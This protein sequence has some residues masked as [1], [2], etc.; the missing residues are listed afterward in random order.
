MKKTP[1]L[2][3][4]IF[5]SIFLFTSSIE[6]PKAYSNGGYSTDPSNP[7][8]GSHDWIAQHAL[9]WLSA[10]E[11]QYI[12]DNLA[13]YLYGTELPDNGGAI[14]GIGDTT[15]HHIYFRANGSL[16]DGVAAHRA[17][18]EYQKALNFLIAKDYANAAKNAGIMS[19]YIAEVSVFAHVRGA[20]TDWG[21]ETGNIHSNYES[22][23]DTRTN[24]YFD[25]YSSYLLF[26]GN[27]QTI[28]AYDAARNL[29]FNTTFDNG[30][31]YTCVWMNNNYNT[32][33]PNSI[34]W[35][36]AG[37]SL[38]LAVNALTD[39]LHT[40]YASSNAQSTPTSS[41]TPTPTTT[42]TSTPSSTPTG[43]PAPAVTISLSESASALNYGNTINFTVSA[44]GGKKPYT[45]TWYVDYQLEENNVSPYFSTDSLG[46]GSH[47]VY[48][49]V[50]DANNNSAKTNTVSF[51][52]LPVSNPSTSLSPIPSPSIPE[53]PQT[54][55]M[56]AVIAIFL[57]VTVGLATYHRRN[58]HNSATFK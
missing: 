39:V 20:S 56:F 55:M 46:V 41:S 6:A 36:R 13:A 52:V 9:D 49:Q 26:D 14:D 47:F 34:Y 32:S 24:T 33:N 2:I 57:I 17:S 58:S 35:N 45:F 25:T 19:H 10:N 37:E 40:L 16:Q 31:I 29:A 22:Y 12:T 1:L 11:K 7:D 44:E 8:Y 54:I 53:F 23:V 4:I 18:E 48:V 42:P 21:A 28:S 15:K 30:G 27:L 50:N 3:T 51:E 5:A 38:N 43:T